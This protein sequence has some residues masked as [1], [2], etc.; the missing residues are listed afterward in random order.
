LSEAG[1]SVADVE[2]GEKFASLDELRGLIMWAEGR[3]SFLNL[4]QAAP[5]RISP[6]LRNGM[7]RI[8]DAHLCAALDAAAALRPAFDEIARRYDAVL[9]P[10][11]PGEA[12]VGLASTGDSIFN[13][14]WTLLHV[15]CISLPRFTGPNDLPVGVQLVAPRYSDAR[16]FKVA[17]CVER[18]LQD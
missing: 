15:P 3:R 13:G 8:D 9:T 2:L 6:G 18:L 7:S 4:L 16:L 10:S 1:A 11:A 5:D 17:R 14:L 12:P